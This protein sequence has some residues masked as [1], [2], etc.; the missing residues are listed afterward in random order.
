METDEYLKLAEVEDRMWYFRALHGHLARELE[1]GGVG[2]GARVLDAGC[3]TGGLIV[4]WK[5]E[6]PQWRVSGVDIMPLACRLARERCGNETD[7][8]EG[9]ITA[10]PCGDGEFDAIVSADVVCQIDRAADAIAEF[11]RVLRLGGIA[12]INVPAYMWLWSYHDNAVHTKHRFTRREMA[13]L[14]EAAGFSV[15]R[16][17]HWNALLF[18]L[19]WGKRKLFRTARDTS[20]VK[21]YPAPLEAAF[22]AT[23]AV[24][25]AWLRAGG[26]WAW[27]SSVLAV[28]RKR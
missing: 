11:F 22:N 4:R 25:H 17:T 26:R 24:E 15:V 14:L 7:I 2:A 27:G 19:V 8:R 10:L 20:D 21:L 13:G 3:G 5:R 6:R 23:M 12:A 1:R 16:V 9:S 28:G 18:P